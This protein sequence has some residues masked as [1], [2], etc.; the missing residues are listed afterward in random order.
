MSIDIALRPPQRSASAGNPTLPSSLIV[1]IVS[2]MI[3]F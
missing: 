1:F 2:N 3:L